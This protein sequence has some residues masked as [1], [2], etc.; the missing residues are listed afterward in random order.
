LRRGMTFSDRAE[1]KHI[2]E[3]AKANDF[4]LASLIEAFV[5]SEAF[6]KR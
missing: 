2:A 6:A 1:L 3:Q 5:V 4:K